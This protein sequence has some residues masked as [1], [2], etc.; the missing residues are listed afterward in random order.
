MEK[1]L[2]P[3]NLFSNQGIYLSNSVR[4]VVPVVT[5]DGKKLNQPSLEIDK[6]FHLL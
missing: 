6:D 4:G 2:T 5:L 1:N 3:E